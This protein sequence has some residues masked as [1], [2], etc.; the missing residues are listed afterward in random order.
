MEPGRWAAAGGGESEPRAVS[1]A[2]ELHRHEQNLLAQGL[3]CRV[4]KGRRQTE[5]FEPIDQV[6]GEQE[7]LKVGFVGEE[8]ACG[9]TPECVIPFELANDQFDAGAIVVKA[10]EVERLQSEI[11][12]QDLVVVAAQLGQRQVLA[13]LLGL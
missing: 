4:P 13:P 8:V 1:S 9:D 6:V 11:A 3:E 7:Q 5:T 2:N 10:P 12:D